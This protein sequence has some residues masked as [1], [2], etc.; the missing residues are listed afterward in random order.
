MIGRWL[1]FIAVRGLIRLV[2]RITA[3][4]LGGALAAGVLVAGAPVTVVALVSAGAAWLRGWP[5]GRLY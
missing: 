1:A 5:P 4:L 3:L 2:A